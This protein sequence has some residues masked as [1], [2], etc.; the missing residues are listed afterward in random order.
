MLAFFLFF[1]AVTGIACSLADFVAASVFFAKLS[2]ADPADFLG[3]VFVAPL[4][5]PFFWTFRV[6]DVCFGMSAKG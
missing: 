3:A 5:A 2:F 6:E 4:A 1:P